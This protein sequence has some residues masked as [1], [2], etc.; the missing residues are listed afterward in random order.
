MSI[1]SLRGSGADYETMAT[2]TQHVKGVCVQLSAATPFAAV[3]GVVVYHGQ[4]AAAN[5]RFTLFDIGTG[6]A[7]AETP[8]LANLSNY[9]YNDYG[10]VSGTQ[11]PFTAAIP[12]GTRLAARMQSSATAVQGARIAVFIWSG[13][14]GVLPTPETYGA[15]TATSLGTAVDAGAV[16]NTK[17]PWIQFTPSCG[18][19]IGQ[20]LIC[21]TLSAGAPGFTDYALDIGMGAAG[22]EVVVL[23]D[24]TYHA[25]DVYNGLNPGVIALPISIPAGSRIAVRLASTTTDATDRVLRVVVVGMGAAAGSTGAGVAYASA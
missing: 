25:L 10:N 22:A 1:A 3:G 17:G 13:V 12:A 24:V 19:A 4:V 16:A 5:D 18:I 6:A 11:F 9:G 14:A 15:I 2:T 8:L 7:G 23:P 20:L 21:A